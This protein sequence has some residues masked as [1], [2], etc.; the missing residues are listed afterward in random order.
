MLRGQKAENKTA[1]LNVKVTPSFK[2]A[3]DKLAA[4]QELSLSDLIE[5]AVWEYARGR[6]AGN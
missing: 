3:L 1:Q 2:T 4:E 6:Q 5:R